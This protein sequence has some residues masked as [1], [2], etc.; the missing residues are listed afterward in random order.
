MVDVD[1]AQ[2]QFNSGGL[3]ALNA[4]IGLIMFGV[5]LDLRTEDF[6][7]VVRLPR[8]PLAGLLAQFL[9][10]PAFTFLLTRVLDPAPSIALG[11]ILIAAC[12]GGN[13]SN[14]LT[15][16]AGGNAA[17][18]VSMSA[19]S[20]VAAIFMTPLNVA[21]WG[22]M[23]PDTA[24][25]LTSIRL[26]PLQMLLVVFLILGLPMLAG[27][28][29]ARWRPRLAARLH[30]PFKYFSVAFFLLFVGFVFWQN[31]DVFTVYIG[32]VIGAVVLHNA[33]ALSSGYGAARLLRLEGRDRRAVTLEVGIQNSALG[34]TLIF[35]FF[36]GLGGM[37][38]V[39]GTWGIWHIIAGLTIASLWSRRPAGVPL[40]APET[41]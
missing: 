38:L 27:M 26:D 35:S 1:A 31:F 6:A 30:G 19:V 12:P 22:S 40:A 32:A 16:F 8:A 20:T 14:F 17:L 29:V 33:L 4:V 37:A 25:I 10:L 34:L 11:M 5:A 2:L 7:R 36:G 23:H 15:H 41:A 13:L 21:V 28:G 18:S 9:V 24:A 39:A 3:W